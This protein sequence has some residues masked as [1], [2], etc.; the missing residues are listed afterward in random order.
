M[1]L[2]VLPLTKWKPSRIVVR[3]QGHRTCLKSTWLQRGCFSNFI[4]LRYFIYIDSWR[5]T[6][7][8]HCCEI[9]RTHHFMCPLYHNGH[10]GQHRRYVGTGCTA[11]MLRVFYEV[12]F[13]SFKFYNSVIAL[14][15][16]PLSHNSSSHSSSI[17]SL[18]PGCPL[19]TCVGVLR[20][21][22]V[23]CLGGGSV[24]LHT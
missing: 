5:Q 6:T 9:M 12:F 24:H 14:S 8:M 4:F 16:C 15:P 19:L 13:F 21:A 22:C 3:L 20:P 11:A 10:T 1:T 18:R 2:L 17:L 7:E 23:C